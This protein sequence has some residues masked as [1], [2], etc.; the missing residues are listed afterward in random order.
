MHGISYLIYPTFLRGRQDEV[1]DNLSIGGGTKAI[2]LL[3]E[4]FIQGLGIYN[5]PIM[6]YGNSIRTFTNHNGLNVGYTT[7]TSGGIAI[8]PDGYVPDKMA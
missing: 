6:S 2:S 3:T 8:M 5:V 1:S 7:G 4:F